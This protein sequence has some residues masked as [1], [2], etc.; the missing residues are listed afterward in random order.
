MLFIVCPRELS[1]FQTIDFYSRDTSVNYS[2]NTRPWASAPIGDKLQI[3]HQRPLEL[4][5]WTALQ[6]GQFEISSS[7]SRDWAVVASTKVMSIGIVMGSEWF[8]GSLSAKAMTLLAW[9]Y[10]HLVDTESVSW[11]VSQ[12]NRRDLRNEH[13]LFPVTR[14]FDVQS[15][16][17]PIIH[18]I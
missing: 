10:S 1:H 12:S 8:N 7:L 3:E 16:V 2:N 6:Q 5:G 17:P 18:D 9:P 13:R 15:Q 4:Q 11:Q 14:F